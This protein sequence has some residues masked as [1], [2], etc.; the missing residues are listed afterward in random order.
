VSSL[1]Y[2]YHLLKL[3]FIDL[4]LA[5]VKLAYWGICQ[6]QYNIRLQIFTYKTYGYAVLG[7]FPVA[8]ILNGEHRKAKL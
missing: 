5:F 8:G 7:T 1:A 3:V 4:S 6:F 2:S